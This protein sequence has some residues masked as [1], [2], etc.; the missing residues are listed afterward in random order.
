MKKILL[1]LAFVVITTTNAQHITDAPWFPK[2]EAEARKQNRPVTFEEVQNA[3]NNYWVDK[4]EDAKGS[5]FKP[6]KRWENRWSHYI[7]PDGTLP[8]SQELWDTYVDFKAMADDAELANLD[9]SKWEPLGPFSHTKNGSWS[10]GQGRIN[11]V[12]QDPKDKNKVYVGAPAGGFWISKDGGKTWKT[13]TDKLPQI[14]VSAIAVDYNNTDIIYMSTGDDD[15]GDTLSIGVFKSTDG[16]ETWEQTGLKASNSPVAISDL[17]IDPKDSNKLW[18]ATSNGVYRTVDACKTWSIALKGQNIKDIKVKP[19]DTNTIYA[20]SPSTVYKSTDSGKNFTKSASGLPTGVQRIVLD[21]TP[22][23][24]DVVYALCTTRTQLKGLYKS[25]NSA[26]SFKTVTRSGLIDSQQSWYDLALGVSDKD[27]NIVFTGELNVWKGTNGSFKKIND[28]A[29]PT[30]R[31]YTHADIHFIR[32]FDGVLYVGSDGGV[33]K[34][35]NNGSSFTNITVGIQNGQFY[36]ISVAKGNVKKIVGGLQDNGGY[37]TSGNSWNNWY[38]ADGMDVAVD[39]TNDNKF[40]GFIQMGQNIYVSNNAGKSKSSEAKGATKGNWITPLT[41][42]AKGELYAGY[43]SLY[44]FSGSWQRVGR[45]AGNADYLEID[46]LNVNNMYVA[47]KTGFYKSSDKGKSFKKLKTFSTTISSIEV[48]NQDSKIIYVTTKGVQNRLQRP[49]SY[50]K[51]YISTDGGSSF[52]DITGDLPNVTKNIIR[53]ESGDRDN[54]LYL[55]TSLGVF[56]YSDSSKKWV[57]FTKGL[58]N[59]SVS[60]I[61]INTNSN[62]IVVSTYGRGIWMSDLDSGLSVDKFDLSTALKVYPNPSRGVFNIK[63]VINNPVNLRVVDVTGKLILSRDSVDFG[64]DEYTLDLSHVSKGVYFLEVNQ[65]N[66]R[67]TKK[68]I[69]K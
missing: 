54:S 13:T 68:L 45:L 6:F 11:V 33:Y 39:P 24:P 10:P 23:N 44:K 41:M 66:S 20:A 51:V 53:H 38:G 67:A 18:A 48:N 26:G 14:G 30:G 17:Y 5:G 59:T 63:S 58:P 64:S 3:F 27:E 50:G 29:Q 47:V 19:G 43:S 12:M 7:Q 8:T 62:K 2:V 15:A 36:R 35:T 32:Y 56:T 40:Y 21:I 31:A 61:E 16:G 1:L 55:G 9:N 52:K 65:V 25:T 46:D 49:Q 22:A 60:D 57:P 28:W 34:S 37:G 69:I 42:N 4:N